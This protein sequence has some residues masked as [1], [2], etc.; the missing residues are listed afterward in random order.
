MVFQ[1]NYKLRDQ[2][3]DLNGQILSLSMYEARSLFG[4]Q[5]KVQSLAAEIDNASRDE[6][7]RGASCDMRCTD[8][9]HGVY[10]GNRWLS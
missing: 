3:D 7:R 10:F 2:N 8:G 1:E 9:P 4:A 5:S 6:V